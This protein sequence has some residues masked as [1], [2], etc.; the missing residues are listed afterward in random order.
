M[1][2]T[3]N[4]WAKQALDQY[5][6]SVVAAAL[7]FSF[8]IEKSDKEGITRATIGEGTVEI[9]N[10]SQEKADELLDILNRDPEKIPRDHQG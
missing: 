9:R 1:T 8:D 4:Y 2:V 10:V 6:A 3:E 7:V 5:L